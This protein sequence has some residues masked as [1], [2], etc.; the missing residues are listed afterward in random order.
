MAPS[1]TREP[2]VAQQVAPRAK[3]HF[4]ILTYGNLAETKRCLASLEATVDE[5]FVV[6][7][8]DNASTDGTQ[9][10]L[11]SRDKPWLRV[12]C[13]EAN[14]GV[15]GGRNDLLAFA[16]PVMQPHEWLVFCDNDL[17]FQKGWLAAF[18][19]AMERFPSARML[20]QVG[21]LVH[22]HG[23]RRTLLPAHDDVGPVDVLSGGFA[24]M[25]RA[26]VAA[27]IGAFDENLGLFWHEDDDWSVRALQLGVELVAVPRAGVVHHE[28]ATGVAND[29]L[30]EGGSLKNQA[31]LAA[32][33]RSNGWIDEGG[34]VRQ[35]SAHYKP[36]ELRSELQRRC[37]RATPIGRAE[38]FAAADLLDRLVDAKDPA[39]DYAQRL[40]SLPM[41][42]SE[43]LAWNRET[44]LACGAHELALQLERIARATAQGS[45]AARLMPLVKSPS[46]SVDGPAGNGLCASADFEDAEWLAAA[47]VLEPGHSMR[48]P[49]ARDLA[50]WQ[51]ASALLAVR[52]A[53]VTGRDATLLLVG[54]AE[55]RLVRAL[56]GMFARVVDFD[57][58]SPPAA[59]TCAAAVFVHAH[60]PSVVAQALRAC[61]ATSLVVVVGD[62][63]L[64]GA[65][66]SWIPQPMQLVHEL[67]PRNGLAPLW[68][69]RTAVDAAVLEACC[70]AN[71]KRNGPKL[72]ALGERL[73]TGFVVAFRREGSARE[74]VSRR[75]VLPTQAQA[76]ALPSRA[77]IGVDLRTVAYADSTARGIGH[78][79]T[80][81]IAAV[82]RRAP[83]LRFVCYLPEGRELPQS[84]RLPNIEA[85]DV[86]AFS[87]ADCDLVH[88]PDPMN[89]AIGFDSPLRAFRHPRTTVLFHDLTPLRHY[90]AQWP[91]AN[92]DAY[93]DR[94]RQI[95]KSDALLLCNSTFTAR[96]AAATLSIDASRTVPVLAGYNGQRSD[97]DPS[98]V[99]RVKAR[100]GIRGPFVL[101]V[102]ALD[103]HK[104][105]AASLSAFLQVR[106]RRPLQFVVVG[107]VD[108]GI[109][110]FALLC[111]KKRIP[112]VVFTGYLP[113]ADLD[114]L[115]ASAA[116]LLFLS[117]AE[118]FGFP[119]LE[120]MAAGCPVIGTAVTSHP[121]VVGDAGMLVPLE[122]AAEHAAVALRR[123]LDEPGLA[124]A[125]RSRGRAQAA[126]FSWDAVAD[127]TIGAWN[128]MLES[129]SRCDPRSDSAAFA[130][131]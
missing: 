92:R 12:H 114:A 107:A 49:H 52:R 61:T 47:D 131:T 50:F 95:E 129:S 10:W 101:H 58:A 106:G 42:W 86:D 7:V 71:S 77:V 57:P 102:G 1:Q 65:P 38:M 17:E 120:A 93:L 123:V 124:D 97:P 94:L 41:C 105:F 20:G 64:D 37:G 28:H 72:S 98:T 19:D 21:H 122:G 111:N 130:A 48:D 6:H 9:Q 117:K 2:S 36:P 68:P 115:Y 90:I 16:L 63:C 70:V 125:L 31:Y 116:S 24:C 88:L 118:G 80:H 126:T 34:W 23:D 8:V 113:R 104:N 30:R 85:R 45:V 99:A 87:A 121:E 3:W 78:Y 11:S 119:L 81:H 51:D 100:L 60:A 112:D 27:A 110:Q 96:D 25:V 5:P 75:D 33:W 22:V 74:A 40:V 44:A 26:D 18:R 82:A 79:T 103:P 108:P 15:P 43:W 76:H 35:T 4:A 91:V 56:R 55:P 89:L 54:R 84:L 66:S 39:V 29:G 32:K 13:N 46:P 128:A 59:G 73:T 127:R 109:E 69:I 83:D 62:A 53:M 14:R 67:G